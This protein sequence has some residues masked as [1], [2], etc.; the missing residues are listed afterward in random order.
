MLTGPFTGSRSHSQLRETAF[1]IIRRV[2][3]PKD[4]NTTAHYDR[5]NTALPYCVFRASVR[6]KT[7]SKAD[8]SCTYSVVADLA[9]QLLRLKRKQFFLQYRQHRCRAAAAGLAARKLAETVG[10][11]LTKCPAGTGAGS[12][13]G[14]RS[15][16]PAATARITESPPRIHQRYLLMGSSPPTGTPRP[17][18]GRVSPPVAEGGATVSPGPSG[19]PP[20][21]ALPC[22]ASPPPCAPCASR[23]IDPLPETVNS[24]WLIRCDVSRHVCLR[25]RIFIHRLE[26]RRAA[27]LKR[28]RLR[29]HHRDIL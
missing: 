14:F 8:F 17:P 1:H 9:F 15:R 23:G 29:Q 24:I 21:A 18:P 22:A 5:T 6:R 10:G 3:A 4:A 11:A 28:H 16:N 19:L 20:L 26:L 13:A 12:G 25:C 7:V 27:R 2:C